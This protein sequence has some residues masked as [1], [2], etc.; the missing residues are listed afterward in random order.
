MDSSP[1]RR[2]ETAQPARQLS[3]H[4]R[5]TAQPPPPRIEPSPPYRVKLSPTPASLPAGK[6]KTTIGC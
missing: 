4:R 6:G 1:S 3:R 5:E 2:R